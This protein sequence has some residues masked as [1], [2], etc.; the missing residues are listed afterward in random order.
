MDPV[1]AIGLV[2]AV[3]STFREV[4][5]IG[6]FIYNTIDHVKKSDIEREDLQVEFMNEMLYL[7]SFGRIYLSKDG[8]MCDAELDQ[9][10]GSTW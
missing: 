1:S 10:Y 6:R 3:S 7:E 5:V 2:T 4:Y 8:L 9:V